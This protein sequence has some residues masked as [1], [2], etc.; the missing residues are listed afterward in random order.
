[1]V[2]TFLLFRR[3]HSTD[4][5]EKKILLYIVNAQTPHIHIP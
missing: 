4:E 5:S 3:Q 2:I 1:M